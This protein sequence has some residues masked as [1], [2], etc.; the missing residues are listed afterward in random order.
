M[1]RKKFTFIVE[2]IF[3]QVFNKEDGEGN[4]TRGMELTTQSSSFSDDNREKAYN[5]AVKEMD[6]ILRYGLKMK[7][8]SILKS[9]ITPSS[10]KQ[11]GIIDLDQWEAENKAMQPTETESQPLQTEET[12]PNPPEE[13]HQTAAVQS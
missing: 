9:V 1:D 13:L 3:E 12:P 4:P 10:I 5:G 7:G 2:V 8:G 6:S 11:V